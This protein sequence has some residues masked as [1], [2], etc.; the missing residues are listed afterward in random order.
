MKKILS[1]V[2]TLYVLG[3]V[4]Y[5]IFGLHILE[6]VSVDSIKAAYQ[7]EYPWQHKK[8]AVVEEKQA[9]VL[10]QETEATPSEIPFANVNNIG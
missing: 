9:P 8:P 3:C 10:M 2:T 6:G 1:A 7:R 4:G 5:G